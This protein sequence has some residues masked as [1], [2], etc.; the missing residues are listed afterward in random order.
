MNKVYF[1]KL[2]PSLH[3]LLI[4]LCTGAF[5]SCGMEDAP[6]SCPVKTAQP[7]TMHIEARQQPA[8][9]A[10]E[11]D[12]KEGENIHSLW[13]FL[14]GADNK[15]E[16]KLTVDNLNDVADYRSQP[17]EE[18]TTGVKTLYAFANFDSYITPGG[19]NYNETLAALLAL[20]K[21]GSFN[22]GG[23]TIDDPA[24]N[25]DIAAGKYI[26][27]SGSTEVTVTDNTTEIGVGMDRLVSKVRLKIKPTDSDVTATRLTVSGF[28]D[29]VP[30]LRGGILTSLNYNKSKTFTDLGVIIQD[31]GL[32]LADFYVNET[33]RPVGGFGVELATTQYS[34]MTYSATTKLKDLPR[35]SIFPL[36]LTFS[37]YTLELDPLAWRAPIGVEPI[38]YTIDDDGNYVIQMLETTSRFQITA[39]KLMKGTSDVSVVTWRWEWDEQNGLA[40]SVTGNVVEGNFSATSGRKYTLRLNASWTVSGKDYDRTY[41]VIID[42][43]DMLGKTTR[44]SGFGA[45]WL[46]PE[47]VNLQPR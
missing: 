3:A 4:G 43:V 37:D 21:D 34:G 23:I 33:D 9:R 30:L 7:V 11:E 19:A 32:T 8:V 35:N 28:A 39:E 12:A 47:T 41:N 18:I 2:R 26:P 17:V 22:A 16:W 42:V 44:S 1:R 46:A 10:D 36:T 13:V 38:E 45:A 40:A 25:I 31:D 6:G 29:R 14:V 20:E 24:A 27:M 5:V 15:V